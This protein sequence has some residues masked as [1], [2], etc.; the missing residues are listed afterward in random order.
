[1]LPAQQVADYSAAHFD[2][3]RLGEDEQF[4]GQMPVPEVL[5]ARSD[6]VLRGLM[7]I[8][9]QANILLDLGPRSPQRQPRPPRKQ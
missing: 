5:W 6:G 2:Q 1:L 3:R 7:V 8:Q 4:P 9:G